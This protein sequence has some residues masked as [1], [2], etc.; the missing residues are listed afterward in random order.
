VK[1]SSKSKNWCGFEKNQI[2]G[3]AIKTFGLKKKDLQHFKTKQEIVDFLKT[4]VPA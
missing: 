1:I 4:L 2:L 3:L